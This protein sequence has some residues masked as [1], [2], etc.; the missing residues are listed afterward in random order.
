MRRSLLLLGLLLLVQG[1]GCFFLPFDPDEE[2]V[3]GSPCL[4]VNLLDGLD[5]TDSAE[6]ENLFD[7]LNQS[8]TFDPLQPV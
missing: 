4:N 6:I 5:E 1:T 8:G 2:M 3:Y 7:C